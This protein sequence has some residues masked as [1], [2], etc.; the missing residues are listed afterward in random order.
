[1]RGFI[2]LIIALITSVIILPLGFIYQLG[3]VLL[4]NC[5]T[6]LFKIAQSIDQLGNVVCTNLFNDTL[7]SKKS[8]YKFGDEDETISSVLGKNKNTNT[9]TFVGKWLAIFLNKIE[10][11][12]VEKAIE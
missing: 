5:D 3:T 12:H 4:K 11:D 9:L 8:V 1:M 6:Y 7:I 10:K 2:L